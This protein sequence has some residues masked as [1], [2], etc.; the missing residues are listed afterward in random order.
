MDTQ[1][2]WTTFKSELYGFIKHKVNDKDLA[3]DILQDVF[4][5]IHSNVDRLKD[6][7]KLTSWVYQLT[8]NT[9]VDFYR[10]KQLPTK[11]FDGIEKDLLSEG[12][13]EDERYCK[14]CVRPF[15]LEL[16]DNYKD[17][18][19]KITYENISQKEYALTNGLAYS[20]VKS[21]IQRGRDQ[22]KK[23]FETCCVDNQ[24]VFE[25]CSDRK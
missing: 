25:C 19:L 8:R 15:I 17:V 6:E 3:D 1:Q 20:T 5:K 4:I 7:K 9:I 22:L 11:E 10:K 12:E 23:S 21:R 14:E 16:P 13:A 24:G 18:M 2:I